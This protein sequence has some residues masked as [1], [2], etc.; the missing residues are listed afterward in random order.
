MSEVTT[1]IPAG[2]EGWVTTNWSQHHYRRDGNAVPIPE[3]FEESFVYFP[4]ASDLDTIHEC[5]IER[6]GQIT[7]PPGWEHPVK[8]PRE[9]Q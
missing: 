7:F 1:H 8:H 5:N 3:L 4:T 2:A 9:R 6:Y